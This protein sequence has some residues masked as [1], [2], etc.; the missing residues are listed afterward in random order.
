M[1]GGSA[2]GLGGR[3]EALDLGPLGLREVAGVTAA[4]CVHASRLG[5]PFP[6]RFE[7]D[8]VATFAVTAAAAT[9]EVEAPLEARTWKPTMVSMNATPFG[10]PNPVVMRGVVLP[11][12]RTRGA[13][14]LKAAEGRV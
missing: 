3:D 14:A 7:P 2:P 10:V 1:H 5:H 11:D 8:I 4:W 13:T 12:R 9:L 6:T